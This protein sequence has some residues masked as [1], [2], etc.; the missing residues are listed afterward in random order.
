MTANAFREELSS[1]VEESIESVRFGIL[2]GMIRSS[3][4][5]ITYT[6]Q[7]RFSETPDHFIAELLGAK[8]LNRKEPIKIISRSFEKITDATTYI[9]GLHKNNGVNV[10]LL[11]LNSINNSI[12]W[13]TLSPGTDHIQ[14]EE[15]LGIKL[16]QNSIRNSVSNIALEIGS[17]CDKTILQNVDLLR[18]ENSNIYYRHI[19][20]LILIRK[21]NYTR[22]Q[23]RDWIR[24]TIEALF[25][26]TGK[27]LGITMSDDNV[28][29]RLAKDLFSLSEQSISERILDLFIQNHS[30]LFANALNYK[31]ALSQVEL[32]WQSRDN[33]DP[34]KSIPDFFMEREDGRYHILDLKKGFLGRTIVKGKTGRRRFIDYIG[35]LIAQLNE[36]E[37]YFLN[38]SN[39]KYAM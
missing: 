26:T 10:P 13:L 6:P 33:N 39:Q 35:E 38:E 21:D 30:D 14:I 31:R 22:K 36:Y 16:I 24:T 28:N 3:H 20:S 29:Q 23:F 5:I 7:I 34:H 37:R 27:V 25:K 15:R 32:V 18:H 11:E 2:Q 9:N 17:K 4:A 8:G 12:S 1:A 19:E